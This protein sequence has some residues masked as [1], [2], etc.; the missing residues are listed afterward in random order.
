MEYDEGK[1]KD[2]VEK[3]GTGEFT[4]KEILKILDKQGIRH[5]ESWKDFIGSAL[6]G[7][8]CFLPGIAKFSNLEILNF[9]AQLPAIKFPMVVIYSMIIVIIFVICIEA[10]VIYWR[11]KKGGLGSE[12]DTIIL[13]KEGPFRIVRHPSVVD[14]TIGFIAITISLS[15]YVPF[16]ILSVIGNITLITTNYWGTLIEEKELNLKK[17]G[18]EYRQY[19][20]EVPRFN[21]IKGLWNLRKRKQ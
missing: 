20:K 19:M 11:K 4:P 13:L 9:F 6:W 15:N 17:W 5:K 14:W 18:N 7:I 21:F 3:L 12:D 2:L 10:Y 1:I 8:L 16:T